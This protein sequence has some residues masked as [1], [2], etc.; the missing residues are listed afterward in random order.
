MITSMGHI[1]PN[2]ASQHFYSYG[3]FLLLRINYIHY[4]A[5][6]R[7]HTQIRD[8]TAAFI[9]G[10][11]SIVNLDWLS[12]FS[13]PEVCLVPAICFSPFFF[14]TANLIWFICCLYFS[15]NVWSPVIQHH[16]IWKIC[17]S[18]HNI[19]EDFMILIESS[20]GCGRFCREILRKKSE[21]YSSR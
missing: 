14:V 11:R 17:A 8:Q 20:A 10:F 2:L 18:I 19:M 9:R 15:C 6:F 5:Y 7:M 3:F 16:W 13:T 21:N 4:M 1:S 12:L